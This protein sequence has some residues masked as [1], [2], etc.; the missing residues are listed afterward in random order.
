MSLDKYWCVI[1]DEDRSVIKDEYWSVI[2][3]RSV[4]KDEQRMIKDNHR[5]IEALIMHRNNDS[6]NKIS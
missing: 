6:L 5:L 3:D 1:K 4:I 2:K